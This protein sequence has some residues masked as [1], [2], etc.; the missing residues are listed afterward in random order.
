MTPKT[1]KELREQARQ[2]GLRGYSKLSK[3]ELMARLG[4]TGAADQST[5][6]ATAKPPVERRARSRPRKP[7]AENAAPATVPVTPVVSPRWWE[8]A[9]TAVM[10]GMNA[11]EQRIE[12][13]K[14]SSAAAAPQEPTFDLGEDIDRLP[15]LRHSCLTLLPQKPGVLHAYWALAEGEAIPSPLHLRLCQASDNALSVWQEAA[16]AER[17]HW[18]FHV[19]ETADPEQLLVQLGYYHDGAFVTAARRAIARLPSLYA[20]ART[21]RWWFIS[22]HDFR[23]LY[24]RAGGAEHRRLSW[25]ASIGSPSGAAPPNERL[26]WPGGISSR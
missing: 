17:G 18:Y 22:E 13:A 3:Q 10:P 11:A 6:A 5:K 1:I 23:Q 24:L 7:A 9:A 14:Y 21:D 15:P 20:S 8:P 12:S 2:L 25:S 19:P 16:V 4:T 26:S